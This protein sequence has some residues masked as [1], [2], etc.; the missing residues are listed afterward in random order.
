MTICSVAQ[1]RFGWASS[2]KDQEWVIVLYDVSQGKPPSQLGAH[3]K[4]TVVEIKISRDINER[5][6]VSI[7]LATKKLMRISFGRESHFQY[8]LT[9]SNYQIFILLNVTVLS[10]QASTMKILFIDF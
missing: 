3:G 2:G 7:D 5:S 8:N 10:R 6:S 9:I 1:R 4:R